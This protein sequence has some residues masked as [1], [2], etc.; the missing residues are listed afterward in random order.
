MA[1]CGSIL[2]HLMCCEVVSQVLPKRSLAAVV[3]AAN[4]LVGNNIHSRTMYS[5]L[6]SA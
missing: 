6:L 3:L 5:M 2:V 4:L 1:V